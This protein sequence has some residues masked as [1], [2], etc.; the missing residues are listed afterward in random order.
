MKLVSASLLCT[1]GLGA[2]CCNHG[3]MG[4]EKAPA[5]PVETPVPSTPAQ[6]TAGAQASSAHKDAPAAA[7]SP[8]QI[9][10][11]HSDALAWLEKQQRPDG[12]WHGDG[13]YERNDVGLTG[14]ALLAL[15]SGGETPASGARADSVQRGVKW[16]ISQQDADEGVIGKREGHS[17]AYDHAIAAQALC[18]ALR[19]TPNDELKHAAQRSVNFIAL[20]R[21]PYGAWRYSYPPTGDNDTSVTGW[22]VE[23]LSSAQAAG[24]TIDQ[25]AFANARHW[26]DDVTDPATGRVGY[27]TIGSRSS[28]ITGINDEF[29]TDRH[30]A[31][32]ASGMVT[33][34]NSGQNAA[35][36]PMLAKH[37]DLLRR[38]LPEWG[39]QDKLVD[40]YYWY[41]GSLAA[42]RM[43]GKMWEAWSRSA[44][45]ALL[46][47]QTQ[48]GDAKGAWDALGPWGYAGGR[49]FSTAL[50]ALSLSTML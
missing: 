43:G 1:V 19:R 46:S 10:T 42:K 35:A 44:N 9:R 13:E 16:L 2:C 29:P 23:A 33:R 4:P 27:D 37:A 40:E 36:T 3:S 14:L 8:V 15:M 39:E 21:N 28:R 7:V 50:N 24:L 41:F 17:W 32:T 47:G 48:S 38:S 12:S 22:M 30:E 26:I 45:V 6:K 5:A 20:M 18:V 11:A 31:M 25:G 34:M 49:V